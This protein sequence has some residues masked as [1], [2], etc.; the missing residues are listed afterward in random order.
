MQAKKCDRCGAFYDE[1][2]T[3]SK[4]ALTQYSDTASR[5]L[6]SVDLCLSC[7]ASLVVWFNKYQEEKD[8]CMSQTTKE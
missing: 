8:K 6:K 4:L 1:A 2:P 3:K 5:Y 7:E